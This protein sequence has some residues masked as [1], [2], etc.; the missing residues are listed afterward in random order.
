MHMCEIIM[1]EE[2]LIQYGGLGVAL[3]LMYK[4]NER[5]ST[6]V[7]NNTEAI[8]RLRDVV[9]SASRQKQYK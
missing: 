2:V 9:I 3:F 1:I 7:E 4:N 8:N 6:A 5:V